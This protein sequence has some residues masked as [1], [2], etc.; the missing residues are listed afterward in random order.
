MVHDYLPMGM[1]VQY[2]PEE[3]DEIP[4]IPVKNRRL[5]N[6]KRLDNLA[7]VIVDRKQKD[8]T[9]GELTATS[10]DESGGFFL[11][12]WVA[13]DEQHHLLVNDLGTAEEFIIA[14]KRYLAVLDMAAGF[15]PYIAVDDEYIIKH[16]GVLG[17]LVNQGRALANHQVELICQKIK[18]RSASHSLDRG[19]SLTIPYFNDQSLALESYNFD[20]IPKGRVMFV[21]AFVVLAV[22]AEELHVAQ[23]MRL[24]HST[25]RHLMK[26]LS[27]L[28]RSF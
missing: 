7:D 14:L 2:I 25:R 17:Q 16:Y 27:V 5:S 9:Q 1:N 18:N 11:P 28:E 21:P 8:K 23:N 3:A 4:S 19:F 15:A 10:G 22:R 12:Q 26:E 24:N 6:P 20:V 13:F